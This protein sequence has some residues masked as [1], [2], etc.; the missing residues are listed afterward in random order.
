MRRLFVLAAV[1]LTLGACR[2]GD[3]E[4]WLDMWEVRPR[5][6]MRHLR[7]EHPRIYAS[8][9]R[10]RPDTSCS[11]WAQ[12]ALDAG[13]SKSQWLDPLHWI[14][15]AES[16]CTPGA[17]SAAGARGL[18]QVMPMWADDCGRGDLYDPWFNLRC[19]LHVYHLQGWGAWDV[20]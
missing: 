12:T 20:Y 14:M 3:V 10:W 1:V 4:S 15:Y 6:A 8:V 7:V 13:W 19:A 16:R 5:A 18:M 11:E 2:P 9:T 17:T